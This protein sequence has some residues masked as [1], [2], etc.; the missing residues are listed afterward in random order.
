M[1]RS[2]VTLDLGGGSVQITF[3]PESS[4]RIE[5][6]TPEHLYSVSILNKRVNMYS[7]R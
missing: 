7:Y 2:V 6:E 4:R 1:S 5:R 3:I